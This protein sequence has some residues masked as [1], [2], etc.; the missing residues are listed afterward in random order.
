MMRPIV[1]ARRTQSI[2]YAVRDI[3]L[4]ARRAREAGR[5]LLYLNIGDPNKFD[6]ETPP[7]VTEAICRALRD[8]RNSYSESEGIPAALEAIRAEAA[9][10]GIQAVHDVFVGNGASECIE[11]A[12]SALVEEGDNVMT[13]SPGYPLYTAVLGKLGCPENPY[14]L[15]EANG[16]QPD[17]DDMA[18]KI[19]ART[20]AIV[21]INPNNPT[22]SVCERRTLERVLELAARHGV[23][24]FADEIYSKLV[25]PAVGS[26]DDGP[27]HL[28]IGSLS[29][30]VPI[31]TFNGLSKAYLGPGL[32][33]GWCIA[34]GPEAVLADYLEAMHKYL[35][36]R[37][38]ASHPVQHAIAPALEG[39]QSHLAQVLAK[40]AARRGLTM[41]RLN[42][43]PGLS[44]VAPRA[45]FYAFPRLEVGEDDATFIPRL[46][47]RTG[48][49]VV[50]G[51][52]FGER[53]GTAHFRVVFLP[54]EE[55][56]RR[57]YDEIRG[58]V[59]AHL[60][61]RRGS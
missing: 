12:L 23:V 20:R 15:D 3:L 10:E 56:L 39:D 28:S 36:A 9:R 54:P 7:H 47:E 4:V 51:S 38:C 45:A 43:V 44:C 61:A 17:V 34:S 48:V 53:P 46:I 8:N 18:R 52:G 33:M 41:S 1:P 16:W 13:P 60:A 22:G 58:F 30:E 6:F 59:A 2:K 40:L 42:G 26:S 21:L 24:V 49:V 11:I 27:R 35:R 32:R 50:P 29:G 5:E 37:L 14:F 31:L 19:D 55:I 57:A 25:L